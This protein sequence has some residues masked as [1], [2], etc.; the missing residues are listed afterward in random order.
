M[1]IPVCT[2]ALLA[3]LWAP[4]PLPRAAELAKVIAAVKPSVVAVGTFEKTRTPPVVF[5]GTG[6]AVGDGLTIVTNAHVV[7]DADAVPGR[8]LG[9]IVTGAGAY[10]FR[11]AVAVELDREHDLALLRITGKPLAPLTLA[12]SDQA[13]EG[14]TLAFTGYPLGMALGLNPATHR[15]MLAAVT[16]AFMPPLNARKLDPAI[17]GKLVSKPFAM[18][19]IDGTAFPGNSGSPL[20]R[21]EDGSVV[22]IINMVW[23][24]DPKGSPGS[25]PSGISYAI[26][27]NFIRDLVNKQPAATNQERNTP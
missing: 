11:P 27:S 3:M 19:Q 13:A 15:A 14:H 2:I 9:V 26:P 10:E 7:L 17:I 8:A 4:A 23:V 20:Y 5:N 22:G 25:G 1:R 24:R 18:F 21:S 12:D 6:F 16:P